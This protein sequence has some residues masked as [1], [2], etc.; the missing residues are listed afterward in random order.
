MKVTILVHFPVIRVSR[1]GHPYPTRTCWVGW[2]LA[3]VILI[4]LLLVTLN[5]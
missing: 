1:L 2:K 5:M 4:C 3:V